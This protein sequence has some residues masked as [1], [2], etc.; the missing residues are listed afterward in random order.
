M[1]QSKHYK[2]WALFEFPVLLSETK[3]CQEFGKEIQEKETFFKHVLNNED[4]VKTTPHSF[5]EDLIKTTPHSGNDN[6]DTFLPLP[7]VGD[8]NNFSAVIYDDLHSQATPEKFSPSRVRTIRRIQENVSNLDRDLAETRMELEST[9]DEHNNLFADVKDQIV[10]VEN[11]FKVCNSNQNERL[12]SQESSIEELKKATQKLRNQYSSLYDQANK[13]KEWLVGECESLREEN[14]ALKQEIEQLK[15]SSACSPLSSQ[16]QPENK[17]HNETVTPEENDA[18]YDIVITP[19]VPIANR[20]VVL[21]EN[22]GEMSKTRDDENTRENNTS[23]SKPETDQNTTTGDRNTL[24]SEK[25]KEEI[26]ILMDSNGKYI[27]TKKLCKNKTTKR[28]VCFT[29]DKAKDIVEKPHFEDP[30]QIL[31]HVGTNDMEQ[32][33]N[34]DCIKSLSNLIS[35]TSKKFPNTKV[36]YSNLLARNDEHQSRVKAL[37]ATIYK[38]IESL[39]NVHVIDNSNISTEFLHDRKHLNKEGVRVFARNIIQAMRGRSTPS[40]SSLTTRQIR[41]TTSSLPRQTPG[42]VSQHL[43]HATNLSAQGPSQESPIRVHPS[44]AQV[45]PH[46]DRPV[47]YSEVVQRGTVNHGGRVN[48]LRDWTVNHPCSH[49]AP[50]VQQQPQDTLKQQLPEQIRQAIH[51]LNNFFYI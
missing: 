25:S 32:L 35:D 16:S 6:A 51:M 26:I 42:T 13:W 3:E 33:S 15:S 45:H 30:K 43:P 11:N 27:N 50:Y 7:P 23:T 40:R 44:T 48:P 22:I 47:N 29:A 5:N 28:I 38:Q 49:E 9:T 20:Y 18:N 10:R 14:I 41:S 17:Y 36:F 12:S 1:V 46:S 37:N 31:I 39:P 19:E 21:S 24:K 2:E 8:D 34:A 4:I